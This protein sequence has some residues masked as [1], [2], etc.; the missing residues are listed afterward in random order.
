M[1]LKNLFNTQDKK[2][3]AIAQFKQ[4]KNNAGWQLVQDI[5]SGNIRVLE[6]QILDG[7]DG[8][9]EQEMNRKR[10]KLRA[11]KEVL[12]APDYWIE[13]LSKPEKFEEDSDPYFTAKELMEARQDTV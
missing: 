4:L 12:N 11:Y 13:R 1:K 3:S 8:A 7:V 2:D 5:F 10:D 9:T 6:Q